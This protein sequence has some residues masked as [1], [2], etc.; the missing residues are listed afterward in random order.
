[1]LLWSHC[2]VS[3][4][5]REKNR[6]GFGSQLLNQKYFLPTAT[7][8]SVSESDCGVS[9]DYWTGA[10]NRLNCDWQGNQKQ[11]RKPLFSL[12]RPTLTELDELLVSGFCSQ[13]NIFE[14][15]INAMQ[16][17]EKTEGR[18]LIEYQWVNFNGLP[19]VKIW[20]RDHIFT[21]FSNSKMYFLYCNYA[22][23]LSEP[24]WFALLCQNVLLY[25]TLKR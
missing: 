3:R 5:Q 25:L 16:S 17:M 21:F 2:G 18:M 13:M 11:D 4:T 19:W 9:L 12:T 14:I 23:L 10:V 1:M 24:L 15:Q 7:Q 20:N 22:P 8:Q 6:P